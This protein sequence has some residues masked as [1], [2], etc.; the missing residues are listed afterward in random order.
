VRTN[1]DAQAVREALDMVDRYE[2][3][4]RGA[5]NARGSIR[6]GQQ[7]AMRSGVLGLWRKRPEGRDYPFTAEETSAIYEALG[8]VRDDFA[9]MARDLEATVI[10]APKDKETK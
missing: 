5:E 2:R 4:S 8:N 3:T 10:M 7:P 1:P 9:R 6:L